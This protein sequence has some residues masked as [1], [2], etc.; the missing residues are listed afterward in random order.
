MKNIDTLFHTTKK[1]DSL[2]SIIENGFYPSYADE[3]IMGKNVKVLMI[4]FSNVA[5]L[6]SR[7]QINYGNYSLGFKRQWGVEN[8]L[9]PVSYTYEESFISNKVNQVLEISRCGSVLGDMFEDLYNKKTEKKFKNEVLDSFNLDYKKLDKDTIVELQKSFLEIFF[10]TSTLFP[11]FKNYRVINKNG[12]YIDAFNDREWRFIPEIDLNE[13]VIFERSLK[14]NDIIN[15]RFEELNKKIKPH[16]KDIS[17]GFTLNDL[18]NIIVDKKYE[19]S[20]TYEILY[21]KF[22][23]KNVDESIKSGNLSINSFENISNNY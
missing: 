19:I 7:S 6:E 1:L 14:L 17:L 23:K 16:R 9:H 3:F 5:F 13:L 4:S 22:G 12:N 11:F 21:K 20:F 10:K 15:P 2:F 8:S 18:T